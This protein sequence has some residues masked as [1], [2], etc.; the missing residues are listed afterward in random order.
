MPNIN[1]NNK[2]TT[3]TLLLNICGFT[4]QIKLKESQD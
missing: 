2:K 1:N 3:G 4:W